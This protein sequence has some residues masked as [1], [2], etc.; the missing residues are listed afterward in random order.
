MVLWSPAAFTYIA[1]LIFV[2]RLGVW[3]ERSS[4]SICTLPAIP[5]FLL[6]RHPSHIH[7]LYQ[8][9]GVLTGSGS[10]RVRR[11]ATFTFSFKSVCLQ[12][13]LLASVKNCVYPEFKFGTVLS[14]A[15][16]WVVHGHFY[17]GVCGHF[18]RAVPGWESTALRC[19]FPYSWYSHIVTIFLIQTAWAVNKGSFGKHAAR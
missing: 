15:G 8:T 4:L 9:G 19:V 2:I 12:T 18:I 11:V 1:I 14:I 7:Y 5:E 6:Q 16:D 10:A 3:I 13:C 17:G